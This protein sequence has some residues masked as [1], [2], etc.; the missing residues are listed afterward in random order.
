MAYGLALGNRA[1]GRTANGFK[2][3]GEAGWNDACNWGTDGDAAAPETEAPSITLISSGGSGNIMVY[4]KRFYRFVF[5][6][7]TLTL[8]NKLSFNSMG[9]IG[10]AT[11]G[12]WDTD[13]EMNFDTQK[14]RFWVDVTLTA[15]GDVQMAIVC[16]RTDGELFRV[17]DGT[18][19]LA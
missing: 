4:S 11:P 18:A 17:R 16:V 12:G 15:P 6:R 8:S 13:T 19:R 14:Q 7:S 5:D 9:I 1:N 10:D 2:L 3:S